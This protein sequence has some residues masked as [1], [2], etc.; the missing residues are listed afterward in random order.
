MDAGIPSSVYKLNQ[1]EID[2][3]RLNRVGSMKMLRVGESMTLD[4]GTKVQFLGTRPYAVLS[5]RHDPG[6]RIVLGSVALLLGGLMLSLTGKR[7]RIW[8]RVSESTTPGSSMVE[9]GG[10]P[11]TDY[12]GFADEFNSIVGKE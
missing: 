4:D 1:G 9:A 3:G 8:F 6:E 7:R 2:A 10:L 11:R 12:P 5:I